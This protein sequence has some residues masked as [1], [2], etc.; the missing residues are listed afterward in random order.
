M[1]ATDPVST[2]ATTFSRISPEFE[3]IEKRAARALRWSGWLRGG[4][5]LTGGPYPERGSPERTNP[6]RRNP[7][8]PN[9]ER[10]NPERRNPAGRNPLRPNPVRPRAPGAPP[11]TRG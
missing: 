11:P 4:R 9:P 6:A 8:R 1:I 7:E 5:R 2:P 3:A 10:R